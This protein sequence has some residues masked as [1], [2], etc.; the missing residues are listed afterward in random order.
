VRVLAA[1]P[2]AETDAKPA[3]DGRG[4]RPLAGEPASDPLAAALA[5]EPD[6]EPARRDGAPLVAAAR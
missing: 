5:T 6:D 4:A 2:A 1:A 3:A